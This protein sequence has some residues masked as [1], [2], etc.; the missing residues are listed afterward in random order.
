M[1]NVLLLL[2]AGFALPAAAQQRPLGVTDSA[3]AW[4]RELF[5]GSANC[6][7]CHGEGGRGTEYV[8]TSPVH[9]GFMGP[10]P[11]SP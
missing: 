5:H 2:L 10:A 11:M 7:A 3:I 1:R 4:G 9:S 8:P 6:A